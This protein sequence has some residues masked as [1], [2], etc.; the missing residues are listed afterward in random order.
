MS[1]SDS[2]DY[3]L[4]DRLAEEF[5]ERYR[6]GERPSVQEYCDR[7]PHIADDLREM[8][9]A[10]AEV[11]QVKDE[12][13]APPAVEPP[14]FREIDDYHILREVGR[15]GMGVVYE[16]DDTRLGRRVALKVLATG[17]AGHALERFKREARAAARL[18]HT[19]IVPVFGVGDHEGLPYYVMQFI[20]GLGLDEVLD[21]VKRLQSRS[22]STVLPSAVRSRP[23]KDISAV[24]VA[25]SLV[26]GTFEPPSNPE[27]FAETR[28]HAPAAVGQVSNL[29]DPS[30]Q[31]GSLSY[32]SGS[33]IS[34]PGQSTLTGR[35]PTY[36]Q[37]VAQI[38]LQV[39]D[40]LDYAHKQGILHR[41]IKPSNLLLDLHGVVWV[42]DFGLAK[43]A[44]QEDLT[45]T[46]DVLG[47]LRYMPP[48]AFEGKSEARSDV[49]SLGLTMYEL[50]TLRPAYDERKKEQLVKQVTTTDPPRLGTLNRA[51]PRDL[52]T[53]V[54]KAIE[55]HPDHRYKSAADLAADLRRFLADQTILARRVSPT[56]RFAR[57]CKRNPTV[58]ALTAA[59]FLLVTSVAL[60]SSVLALRIEQKA[61]EAQAEA[62]RAN[63]EADRKELA[64]QAEAAERDRANQEAA[65]KSLA[66]EEAAKE[67][68]RTEELVGEQFVHRGAGLLADGDV[69]GAALC[70]AQALKLDPNDPERALTH[71]I[72][73]AAALRDAPRPRHALFHDA[74]VI[75]AVPSRDGKLLA[76][77]C[78][79]R[80]VR[81]W[82]LAT[83][84]RVGPVITLKDDIDHV[85]FAAQD[86]RLWILTKPA[87]PAAPAEIDPDDDPPLENSKFEASLWERE[88]GKMIFSGKRNYGTQFTAFD[89]VT[90]KGI[91]A[92]NPEPN[93]L[94]IHD[95]DTGALKRPATRLPGMNALS[96]GSFRA[97]REIV[98]IRVEVKRPEPK[99][100]EGKAVGPKTPS[101]PRKVYEYE[102][103]VYDGTTGEQVFTTGRSPISDAYVCGTDDHQLVVLESG[104]GAL[105]WY[106]LATG[107]TGPRVALPN[108]VPITF[109]PGG[110]ARPL[111]PQVSIS[112]DHRRVVVS[113]PPGSRVT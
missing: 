15:G 1:P 73:L 94:E 75:C 79:D 22:G 66:L 41:D 104:R 89:P 49:Y 60:V 112:A 105:Q 16:A 74:R 80:T 13:Q 63:D 56:E 48:E 50:L 88:T 87:A 109:G 5:A 21:E 70:F 68:R 11:E 26:T 47:T 58:A 98:A 64:L 69:A 57:W 111:A 95:R 72:R 83:G 43:A 106:D 30:G 78:E 7:H 24:A 97:N 25:R 107:R 77:G 71:R 62:D 6:N 96:M 54:H 31:V 19:N 8:L 76:T 84:E 28:T 42:T 9:P 93:V 37:S 18:H 40:A 4:I 23:R 44:D 67:R 102:F 51:I 35:K 113:H 53:I 12:V 86:R 108:T 103:Q 91:V 59:V 14:K 90:G 101:T 10:L 82:D 33:S 45:H 81:V 99:A 100:P 36:W 32:A 2:R 27:A 3:D 46:G 20:Q 55:K 61:R 17:K 39:A 110:A 52:Q 34:L 85:N 38:G 65:R 29:S 92:F